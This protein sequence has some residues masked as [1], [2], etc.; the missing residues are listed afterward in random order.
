MVGFYINLLSRTRLAF[1]TLIFFKYLVLFCFTC[2]LLFASLRVL[3]LDHF[4]RGVMHRH[5]SN[6]FIIKKTGGFL[7]YLSSFDNFLLKFLQTILPNICSSSSGASCILLLLHYIFERGLLFIL[8]HLELPQPFFYCVVPF[9]YN[10]HIN[11]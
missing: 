6:P 3:F 8:T 1:C 2:P 7:W 11:L 10:A 4:S 9:I 5:K